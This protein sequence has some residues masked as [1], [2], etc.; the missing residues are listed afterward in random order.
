MIKSFAPAI[1]V[2]GLL[3]STSAFAQAAAPA[4]G[5]CAPAAAKADDGN[6]AYAVGGLPT[7]APAT[8]CAAPGAGAGV[9]GA[10]TKWSSKSSIVA[11]MNNPAAKAVMA[12]ALPDL[13]P[14]LEMFLDMIPAEATLDGLPD[15]SM[16]MVSA[17][18][19]KAINADL[20]KIS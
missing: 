12:K 2:I 3:A 18:Q 19:V 5:A 13:I 8:T 4:A 10:S 17:D 1:V 9:G 6:S 7:A 15:L 20:I 11:I 14:I 16:G